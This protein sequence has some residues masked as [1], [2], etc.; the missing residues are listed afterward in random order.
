MGRYHDLIANLREPTQSLRNAIP[1]AWTGFNHL[2]AGTM[3]DGVVPLHTKEA[4][5]LAIAAVRHCEPCIAY[6]AKAAVKAGAEPDEVAE[7]LGVVMLMDGGPATGYGPMAWDAYREF[8]SA[9]GSRA[10]NESVEFQ[11]ARR[12]P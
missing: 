2:H 12:E 3:R 8:K 5:A 6:H 10:E 7:I 9:S 11:A 4:I 1:E